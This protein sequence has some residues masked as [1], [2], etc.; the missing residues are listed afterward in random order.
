LLLAAV[1]GVGAFTLPDGTSSALVLNP[2]PVPLCRH[3]FVYDWRVWPVAE[4]RAVMLE[5]GFA[6]TAVCVDN[7]DE[8][9]YSHS[10]EP[11]VSK[12]EFDKAVEGEEF[13]SCYIVC[14]LE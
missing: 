12:E 13:F 4:M 11:L 1:N 5:A 2:A 3:A 6:R 8:D 9:G 14:Y 7:V 10:F